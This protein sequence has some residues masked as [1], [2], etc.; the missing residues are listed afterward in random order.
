MVN[1][2]IL[3]IFTV[4]FFASCGGNK[5]SKNIFSINQTAGV[6]SL[7]P[8]FAKN[9]NIMTHTNNLYN[10][11]IEYDD[12]MNVI[13]SLAKSWTVSS[14]RK[15]YTFTIRNDVFFH[16]NDAFPNGKGRKLSAYDVAY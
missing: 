5:K 11:L 3:L 8:A 2:F 14:D 4:V 13:P 6:E 9:L 7:D 10:R 1:R 16:D 12:S 15:T